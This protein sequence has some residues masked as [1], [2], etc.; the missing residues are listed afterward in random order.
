MRSGK[1][2]L[3]LTRSSFVLRKYNF[4]QPTPLGVLIPC[5]RRPRLAVAA[6]YYIKSYLLLQAY[7]NVTV[8]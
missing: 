4:S 6:I 3:N 2:E 8:E 7:N 1:E 5:K